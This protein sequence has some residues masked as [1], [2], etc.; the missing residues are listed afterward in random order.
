MI[1]LTKTNL[2][3]QRFN[4]KHSTQ[5]NFAYENDVINFTR[6]YFHGQWFKYKDENLILEPKALPYRY[7]FILHTISLILRP[8]ALNEHNLQ[9]RKGIHKHYINLPISRKSILSSS[10]VKQL[11]FVLHFTPTN[12]C[13]Q[14]FPNLTYQFIGNFNLFIHKQNIIYSYNMNRNFK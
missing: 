14:P 8:S 7:K 4:S 5:G 1:C 9:E 13:R 6:E 11:S 10:V 3:S 12:S 2:S